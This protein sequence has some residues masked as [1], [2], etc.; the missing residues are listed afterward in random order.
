[1]IQAG[2]KSLLEGLQ[3]PLIPAMALAHTYLDF[4]KAPTQEH[5][6]DSRP[7]SEIKCPWSSRK[8]ESKLSCPPTFTMSPLMASYQA[9]YALESLFKGHQPLGYRGGFR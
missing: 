3:M 5:M 7:H 6:L 4:K 9:P 1:M 8:S 2:A